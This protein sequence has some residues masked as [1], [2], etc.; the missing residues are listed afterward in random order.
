MAEGGT[1]GSHF[2]TPIQGWSEAWD[3]MLCQ[4]GQAIVAKV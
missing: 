4:R 2:R 3:Q 1:T